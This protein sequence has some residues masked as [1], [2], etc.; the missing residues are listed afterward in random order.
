MCSAADTTTSHDKDTMIK[1]RPRENCLFRAC[2]PL[3]KCSKHLD[4]QLSRDIEVMLSATASE[5]IV[6]FYSAAKNKNMKN[7]I[8]ESARVWLS[9]HSQRSAP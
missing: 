9:I 7:T 5:R 2:P 4:K 3:V 6:G 1:W 8:S